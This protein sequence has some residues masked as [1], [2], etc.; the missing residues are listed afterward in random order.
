MRTLAIRRCALSLSAA[1]ALLPGCGGAQQ[2][3]AIAPPLTGGDRVSPALSYRLLVKFELGR[4]THPRAPLVDVNG[5]LYGTTEFGGK[6]DLGT[7]FEISPSGHQVVLHDFGGSADGTKPSAGLID[8]NGTLYGTT[9]TGGSSGAGTVYGIS[10]TG[11]ESVLYSFTGGSDGGFPLAPLVEVN[12]ALYGTTE[13]GGASNCNGAKPGCGTVYSVSTSGSEQVLHSFAGG[14]DGRIPFAGLLDVNGLLYGTTAFGG[15]TRCDYGSGCGTVYS[16]STAGT[17]KV[18]HK[19]TGGSDGGSPSSGLI[20]V[21]GRLYGTT[22]YG[23]TGCGGG[24]GYGEGCGLVY[25]V[26]TTGVQKVLYRFAGGSDADGEIPEGS[27]L[28]VNGAL[29][30]TTWLGGADC[31]DF[32]GP[33]TIFSVSKAGTEKVLYRFSRSDGQNPGGGLIDVN[34]VLY[35]TTTF[36]GAH[37]PHDNDGGCGTVFAL[38]P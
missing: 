2:P 22:E 35:G 6:F 18:L 10:T 25:S 3:F 37:C 34:G 24:S 28:N 32:C 30:G 33:G 26:S 11:A 12:G 8:V 27:L 20:E 31:E 7:V 5:T 19:F 21:N 17:E 29:Y 38:S 1:A 14:S 16:I 4:G 15:G 23:G 9:Y 36:G 13:Y